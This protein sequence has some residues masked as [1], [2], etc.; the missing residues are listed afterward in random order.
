MSPYQKWSKEASLTK[1][2]GWYT[3]MEYKVYL[4]W[5]KDMAKVT[6]KYQITIPPKVRKALGIVPG[7]EVDIT[8]EGNKYVLVADPIAA[9]KKKWRGKRKDG[10]T[11]MEYLDNVRG[12]VG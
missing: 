4:L 10:G 9:I 7:A 3:I 5:R 1:T 12:R 11:T 2:A 8:R 6:A